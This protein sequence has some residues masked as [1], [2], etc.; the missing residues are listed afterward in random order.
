MKQIKLKIK[1]CA[2]CIFV[3][4]IRG[5][6]HCYNP[7]ETHKGRIIPNPDVINVYCILEDWQGD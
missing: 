6:Y 5:I 7:E 1:K 2:D 4:Y 3:E